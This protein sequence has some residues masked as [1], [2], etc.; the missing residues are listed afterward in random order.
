[1]I[2]SMLVMAVGISHPSPWSLVSKLESPYMHDA[3]RWIK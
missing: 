3:R 1:M 2:C